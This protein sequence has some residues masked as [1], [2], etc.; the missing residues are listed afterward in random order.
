MPSWLRADLSMRLHATCRN[1]ETNTLS[2]LFT[3]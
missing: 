1:M 2:T 3:L